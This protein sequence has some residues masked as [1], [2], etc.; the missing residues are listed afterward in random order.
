MNILVMF[1]YAGVGF[2]LLLLV[3]LVILMLRV[4]RTYIFLGLKAEF[5][6]WLIFLIGVVSQGVST[7]DQNLLLLVTVFLGIRNITLLAQIMGNPRKN[8]NKWKITK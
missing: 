3:T 8:N 5:F 4:R 2:H 1:F 7:L 6:F